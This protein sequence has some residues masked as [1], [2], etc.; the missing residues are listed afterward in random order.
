[1][2]SWGAAWGL[3]GGGAWGDITNITMGG[4]GLNNSR[5]EQEESYINQLHDEDET[6]IFT[7]AALVA[8]GRLH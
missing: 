2:S 3:S 4:K 6:L 5:H 1:M 7:I 8:S